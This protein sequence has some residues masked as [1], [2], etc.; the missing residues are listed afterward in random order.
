MKNKNEYPENPY[1]KEIPEFTEQGIKLY[2]AF[3]K[4]GGSLLRAIALHLE[5]DEKLL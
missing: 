2:K 5:L 1:T 3:E 4:S